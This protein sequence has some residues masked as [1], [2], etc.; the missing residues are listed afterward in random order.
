MQSL[1]APTP[2]DFRILSDSFDALSNKSEIV[3][4]ENAAETQRIFD[5][6]LNHINLSKAAT[7][8]FQNLFRLKSNFGQ[9]YIG[10]LLIDFGYPRGSHG[11]ATSGHQYL[12]Q[13][14]GIANLSIDLGQTHLRP[15]TKLD[16]LVGIVFKSDIDFETSPNFSDKY[17]L[18]SN[19]PKSVEQYF[20]R[21]FRDTISKYDNILLTVQEKM[22]FVT[23]DEELTTQHTRI[24]QDIIHK[25]KY[26]ADK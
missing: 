3:I 11:T 22:M 5:S 13:I 15:E 17:Y 18:A 23:F 1:N 9:Y 14:V 25:F 21:N 2:F 19:N 10:Q 20:D 6:V 7:F 26:L 4:V 24:A 8:S 16:K 12:Y